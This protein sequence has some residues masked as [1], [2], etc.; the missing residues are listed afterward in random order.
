MAQSWEP[1]PE[2]PHASAS[3]V[4]QSPALPPAATVATAYVPHH[5]APPR[6]SRFS[7]WL[8]AA[9]VMLAYVAWHWGDVADLVDDLRTPAPAYAL[10][11]VASLSAEAPE[12]GYAV[13]GSDDLVRHIERELIAHTAR[14][15]VTEWSRTDEDFDKVWDAWQEAI[16]QNPYVYVDGGHAYRVPGRVEI[17]PDY[18]H[19]AEESERRRA[20]TV[21]AARAGVE[22][23]GVAAAPDDATKVGLIYDYIAAVA[24]Y[25]V[26]A[27]EEIEREASSDR[28]DHSQEAYGILVD[29]Y[30]VCRGYSKAFLAMAHEAGLDAVEV[31]GSD[32][33]GRFGGSHAWNKVRVDGRWLLV[34]ITWDDDGSRAG[35]DYLLLPDDADR[36]ETRTADQR[37]M[38]D[39]RMADYRS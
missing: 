10:P 2:D 9:V 21:S 28:V 1:A 39:A 33:A 7:G 12:Q 36:L 13:F 4:M 24:E 3:T 26:E 23:A 32:N 11:E 25:D 18:N 15:D 35:D 31:T 20:L 6:R 17:R 29:G 30:A 22:A 16:A 14:I 27:A 8:V 38:T 5:P 34:D 37:W 19:S